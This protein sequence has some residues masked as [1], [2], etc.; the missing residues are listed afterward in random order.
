M[1]WLTTALKNLHDFINWHLQVTVAT[2]PSIEKH[3]DLTL[4]E[5]A[6]LESCIDNKLLKQYVVFTKNGNEAYIVFKVSEVRKLVNLRRR[7][8]MNR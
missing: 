2:M 4:D 3:F 8:E 1:T 5:I 6:M 7:N